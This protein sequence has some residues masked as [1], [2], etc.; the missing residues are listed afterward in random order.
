TPSPAAGNGSAMRAAPIGLY[1]YDDPDQLVQAAHDQGRITHQDPRCSAGA[2]AIAGA[3]AVALE[4]ETIEPPRFL[5]QLSGWV[6]R[7]EPS[8]A[9]AIRQLA[10]WIT[11]PPEEAVAHIS[12]AGLAPG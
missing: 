6:E 3:V 9:E 2:V 5:N 11:L 7:I 4:S 10:V 8:V 1:F 12:I